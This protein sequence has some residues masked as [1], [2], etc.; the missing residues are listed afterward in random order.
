MQGGIRYKKR[1]ENAADYLSTH[2]NTQAATA[3]K[4]GS[5]PV[6]PHKII[7]DFL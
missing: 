2:R 7:D 3:T 1:A 5:A 4:Q 6:Y